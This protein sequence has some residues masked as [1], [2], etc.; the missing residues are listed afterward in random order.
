MHYEKLGRSLILFVPK[1]RT[2]P[3]SRL[4]Y[5][6]ITDKVYSTKLNPIVGCSLRIGAHLADICVKK[7][8]WL[9][10]GGRDLLWRSLDCQFSIGLKKWYVLSV[11][12]S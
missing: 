7:Y 9:Y 4:E 3:G 11:H 2:D 6:D 1:Y 5:L 12:Q 8:G 10:I